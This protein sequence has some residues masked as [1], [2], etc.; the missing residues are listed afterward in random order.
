LV[1]PL[2]ALPVA[3]IAEPIAGDPVLWQANNTAP[4]SPSAY[5]EVYAVE[6]GPQSSSI[7]SV[8]IN[9]ANT[10]LTFRSTAS[11]HGFGDVISD[12]TNR[13]SGWLTTDLKNLPCRNDL[14]CGFLNSGV[15][16]KPRVGSGAFDLQGVDS[17]GIK[18]LEMNEFA[19]NSSGLAAD[20][21]YDFTFSIHAAHESNPL[22]LFGLFLGAA[23]YLR[24]S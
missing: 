18:I 24:K 20:L 9:P 23:F 2:L 21:A 4:N 22:L 15:L 5:V 19:L 8:A 12:I 10:G 6:A 1:L 7:F 16:G 17:R 13:N 11:E 3:G 14:S